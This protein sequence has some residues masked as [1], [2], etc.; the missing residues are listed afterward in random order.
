MFTRNAPHSFV[1][2]GTSYEDDRLPP[3]LRPRLRLASGARGSAGCRCRRGKAGPILR[4]KHRPRRYSS[5]RHDA[6]IRLMKLIDRYILREL[7]GPFL[8]GVAVVILLFE[9]SIL[10]PLIDTIVEK[11]VPIALVG[12]ILLLKV[13]YLIV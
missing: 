2:L 7:V 5:V 13:P 4:R 6:I 1:K 9:G 11:K 12:R 10:F 8:F 3:R